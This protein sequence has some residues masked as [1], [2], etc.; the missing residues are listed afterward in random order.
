MKF[1]KGDVLKIKDEGWIVKVLSSCRDEGKNWY[2][3][4]PVEFKSIPREIEESRLCRVVQ[5]CKGE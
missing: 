3:V 2:E 1:K 5:P 4:T